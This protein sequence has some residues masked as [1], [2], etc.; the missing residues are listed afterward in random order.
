MSASSSTVDAPVVWAAA[1]ERNSFYRAQV[2]VSF[3]TSAPGLVGSINNQFQQLSY[4]CIDGMPTDRHSV[5]G[6]EKLKL[7]L[8]LIEMAKDAA[9]KAV[10][11]TRA[12]DPPP[13]LSHTHAQQPWDSS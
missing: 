3:N 12:V 1:A 7:A 6:D 11:L 8:Q 4:I 2:G 5:H 10:I 9:V 13:S